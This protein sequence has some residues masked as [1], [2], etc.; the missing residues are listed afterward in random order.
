MK[1]MKYLLVLFITATIV[2]CNKEEME[3]PDNFK[4]L[5]EQFADL[6]I[7][8]YKIHGFDELFLKEKEMLY[9]LYEAAL[10]GRDIY[11]DQNYKNNLKIRR[12][13]EAI[14]DSYTGDRN[15]ED[16]K[17]FMVYTKRVWFSN[18]IH[19]HYSNMKIIPDFPKE[20]F[21]ELV[22]NSDASKFPLAKDQTIEHLVSFLTPI[23]FDPNIA[24]KKVNL[25]PN[26]DLIKTSAV[27]FYGDGLTQKDVENFY[28]KMEKKNDPQPIWYGLNS[29]LV[30]ENGTIKEKVWKVGGMYSPAIEKIVFWLEKASSLAENNTQKAALDKLI[31]YYKTGNLKTWD[32]YNILWASDTTSRIDVVNGFVETYDDP[33]GHKGSFESVVSIKDLEAT[34]RIDAIS[35]QAQWFEDNSPIMDEHKKKKVVGITAKV[36]TVVSETGDSSPSTPIGINLPN[37]TWIRKEHGSKSVSLGNINESYNK[38][39]TK[40]SIEEFAYSEE[41]IRLSKEHST[42]A[43]DLHTDLHEVIGHASGQ[44]NPGVGTPDQTLKHYAST[45]E[46]ARA[47]LVALYYAVDQK[48]VDIGVMSTVDVGKAEYNTYIRNGLM[49]QLRRIIPGDDIEE[50]H[51][52]NRQMISKWVYEK[53]TEENLSDGKAGVIEKKIKDGKSY[54]VIN[55]YQKLRGLFG[56]LLREVQRITSEGDYEA[57]KNLVETYGVKVDIDLNKEVIERYK[58]LNVAPYKGFINPKLIP[59]YE[60]EKIVDVKVE[61]PEDFTEQMMDY[62][63]NHSFLP[64][65]N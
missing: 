18:G 10:A 14:V 61:Y 42:L 52:R 41:E 49:L 26:A 43:G 64:T 59:V 44:I 50:S 32:E 19:H 35:K 11:Y 13:L 38:A 15:S 29:K 1:T 24:R 5:T 30:K 9:Y 4:Y 46:E 48:L 36:I 8:R 20:Y 56:E 47:D 17:Q 2:N 40:G 7:L 25:D 60:G 58:K 57:A 55:D 33:L 54:F 53:G 39:S 28:S 6:G 27:N 62:A 16:F 34:K 21:A 63:K 37:S 65:S 45:I 23:I 3:Q 31:E 12:T 22:N 51:M